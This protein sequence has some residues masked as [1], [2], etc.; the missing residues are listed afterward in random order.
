M[1]SPFIS[2]P[3]YLGNSPPVLVPAVSSWAL[4]IGWTSV[5]LPTCEAE[6]TGKL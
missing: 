2:V 1:G 5:A 3:W 6:Q 4:F